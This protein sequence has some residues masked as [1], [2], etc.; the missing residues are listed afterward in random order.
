MKY[1]PILATSVVLAACAAQPEAVV[2]PV[3]NSARAP[4]VVAQCIAQKWAD[5]QQQPVT[6]QNELANDQALDVLLPGQK[7]G[8]AAAIVRP[9]T[10]GSGS[11]VG[12]RTGGGAYREAAADING[13][14]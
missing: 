4:K 14:L 1:L 2:Q 12:I 9:A 7:P 10:T 8:G 3:G 13:C 6:L 5:K 11:W